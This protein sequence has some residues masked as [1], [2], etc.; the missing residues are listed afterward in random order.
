MSGAKTIT[1]QTNAPAERTYTRI[2]APRDVSGGARTGTT[3]AGLRNLPQYS[4]ANMMVST[5]RVTAGSAGSSL[6][7]CNARS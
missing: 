3:R 7:N 6:P 4:L 5:R 1:S 2:I